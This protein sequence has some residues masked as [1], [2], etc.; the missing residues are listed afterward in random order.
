M[1]PYEAM[2]VLRN[3]TYKPGWRLDYRVLNAVL[4]FAWAFD[5][6]DA[7]TGEP[8]QGRGGET[9]R[10]VGTIDGPETL[11]RLA[12][13]NALAVEEHEAREFFRYQGNRTFNPHVA[14]IDPDDDNY[15]AG[16]F[17]F[18]VGD[19]V[20]VEGDIPGLKRPPKSNKGIIKYTYESDD[21]GLDYRV[22]TG[23]G[24]DRETYWYDAHQLTKERPTTALQTHA[25]L[26]GHTTPGA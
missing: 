13:M 7:I 2:A 9:H 15:Q 16:V 19:R 8:G 26:L 18:A 21:D 6:P 3:I 22:E 5:R 23:E 12:F 1:N 4:I 25:D 11:V 17:A 24:D 10:L 14:L 20:I